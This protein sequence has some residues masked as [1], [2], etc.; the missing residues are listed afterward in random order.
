MST[1]SNRAKLLACT[2]AAAGL[3]ALSPTVASAATVDPSAAS[4][5][6]AAAVSNVP[7]AK[8]E[9]GGGIHPLF[10][11]ENNPCIM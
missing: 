11:S 2:A 1:M 7:S 10:C 3:L 9:L 4:H 8:A 5:R 6:S